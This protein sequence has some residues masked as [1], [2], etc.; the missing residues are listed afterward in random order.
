MRIQGE[1]KEGVERKKKE[2][3]E[4]RRKKNERIKEREEVARIEFN[5]MCSIIRVNEFYG[6]D[7]CGSERI[8]SKFW[9]CSERESSGRESSER[10]W[11]G[12]NLRQERK[13]NKEWREEIDRREGNNGE[14]E[15]KGR[16]KEG[17]KERVKSNC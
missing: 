9:K 13:E 14:S 12:R 15:R 17:E 1:R 8:L 5:V 10:V 16:E 4:R 3:K 2:K 6:W 11:H 7:K